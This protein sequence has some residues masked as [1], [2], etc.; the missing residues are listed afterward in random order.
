MAWNSGYRYFIDFVQDVDSS[1][2]IGWYCSKKLN[3]AH[4][5][6]PERRHKMGQLFHKELDDQTMNRDILEGQWKQ[7]RGQAKMWW[8]GITDD[9][10]DRVAGNYDVI[11]GLLQEKLGYTR[12]RAEEEIDKRMA[13]YEASLKK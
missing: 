5:S 12:Q 4:Y 6:C 3:P 9:D 7:M 8:G 2:Q 11:A 10:F 13:E 1:Y